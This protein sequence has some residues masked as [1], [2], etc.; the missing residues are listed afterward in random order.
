MQRIRISHIQLGQT[1]E[2]SLFLSSGQKLLGPGIAITERHLAAMRRSGDTE[3][4]A[5]D[6]V[7][8]L[9]D[10]GML[11]RY[12]ASSL[13]VGQ[14]SAQ[15]VLTRG[16]Q[17]L[18]EPGQEVEQHHLDAVEAGGD[19][20]YQSDEDE[21]G[22]ER[23]DRI[24]MADALLD[25]LEQQI[26][27][28]PLRVKAAGQT[29]WLAPS[30][31]DDWPHPDRLSAQRDQKVE[32]L[33]EIFAKIEAGVNLPLSTFDPILDEL[34]DCLTHHPTR[35]TQ[36]A[37]LCPRRQ[38][39]LPDHAYT[40][41][42][43][44]MSIAANMTWPKDDVRRIGLA[45]LIA[46]LGMLLV[47]ERI[48][49]GGCE[50]T[51]VDRSRVHRHPVFTLAML[52]AVDDVPALVQL[53]GVQH[54]ERENSSGY[55]RGKRKEA[56][57]DYARLLAVADTFAAGTEPR[58]YRRRKLP[59]TV[60]EETLRAASNVELWT[61][62]CRGLVQSA[63]LFPVGSYVR[64]TSGD[65]AHVIESNPRYVDRPVVQPLDAEGE[66]KQKPIDLGRLNKQQLA[67]VRP[68][69]SATG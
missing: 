16:G 15:G 57:C 22:G 36:L 24:L 7:D 35:F 23:R 50:L 58:H 43:L 5:A 59:Y 20:V 60:M 8:D 69:A 28:L 1:F 17:V 13:S 68:I 67:V 34:M 25:E 55:P 9:A 29:P 48:R 31:A 11:N 45:G 6:S 54:H 32:A 2:Q 40:V 30:P 18:L 37:L 47:P 3:V 63:G 41:A 62:A 64:L 52:Q 10:A 51:D 19:A 27:T 42:V 49:T 61:P 53:A 4:V 65:N 21:A 14:R 39:Y 26:P 12:D 66:P 56:I 46:D 33:R 38:D 44:A